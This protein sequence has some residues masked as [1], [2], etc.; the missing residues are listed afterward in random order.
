MLPIRP[1][2]RN[3]LLAAALL[4]ACAVCVARPSPW[5]GAL[6]GAAL[7]TA[8]PPHA[9]CAAAHN[10][11]RTGIH[12]IAALWHAS[13]ELQRLRDENRALREALARQT[14]ATRQAQA[15]LRDLQGFQAYRATHP[16]RTLAVLAANVVGADPS[17]WR[18]CLIIDRGSADGLRPGAAAVWGNSI[19]GTVV[20]LRPHAATVRLLNDSRAGLAVRVARTGDV[21]LLRGSAD[22]HG[23]LRLKWIHLQPIEQGDTIVTAALDPAV[24][25][26]LVAGRIAHASRTRQPLFY[27]ATVRPLLHLD[28][29]TELL[30]VHYTPDDVDTLLQQQ[31][32]PAK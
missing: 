26:G 23:L 4:A 24:P 14:H 6:R 17:P 12:R 13:D 2:S 9:L 15:Q 5:Q 25:P 3:R 22:R 27:Q 21:G 32:Q 16:S 31:Q 19:V 29:L 8:R 18:H 7:A 10:G 28:R 20:A 11:L 30:V 1:A